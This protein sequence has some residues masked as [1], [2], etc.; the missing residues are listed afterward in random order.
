MIAYRHLKNSSDLFTSNHGI[1]EHPHRSL[2]IYK[3]QN[4]MLMAEDAMEMM[5]QRQTMNR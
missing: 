5:R 1:Q 4:G 3:V 2:T